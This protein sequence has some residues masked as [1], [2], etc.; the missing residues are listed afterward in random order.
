MRERERV[1]FKKQK[2]SQWRSALFC[3][4]IRS[5]N[6]I[7]YVYSKNT[8]GLLCSSHMNHR[9]RLSLTSLTGALHI[10][11]SKVK[12]KYKNFLDNNR[13]IWQPWDQSWEKKELLL[14]QNQSRKVERTQCPSTVLTFKSIVSIP[15]HWVVYLKIWLN[16]L[17][18]LT[19]S[20]SL[21]SSVKPHN[22]SAHCWRC[23][24]HHQCT[25]CRSECVCLLGIW[26]H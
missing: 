17:I 20:T 16:L 5:P 3:V 10:D 12:G 15:T 1:T 23:A 11:W 19:N 7:L 26:P 6:I 4:F 14:F 22:L 21:R 8:T 24:D 18:V 9:I 13:E 2:R 25:I